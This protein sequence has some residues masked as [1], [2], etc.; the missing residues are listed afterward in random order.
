MS[1]EEEADLL[2]DMI[3]QLPPEPDASIERSQ[4][5]QFRDPIRKE[6]IPMVGDNVP[7]KIGMTYVQDELEPCKPTE[8]Q[9]YYPGPRPI[10]KPK[11]SQM[12]LKHS[13]A[14]TAEHSLQVTAKEFK[15]IQ[16]PKILK[17]K[18]GYSANAT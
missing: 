6:S 10:P 8:A 1:E 3:D 14:G 11:R 2:N 16:E 13:M 12:A 17:L 4:N 9:V 7:S 5:V 18:G 15:K